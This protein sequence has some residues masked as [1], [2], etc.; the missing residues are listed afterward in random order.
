MKSKKVL[1]VGIDG[2]DW[3]YINYGIKKGKLPTIKKI[4]D[5]GIYGNLKSTIPPLTFPAWLC[6]CSGKNP[7]KIGY[8][9]YTRK[10]K[11]SYK[12]EVDIADSFSTITPFWKKLNEN[13]I[14]TG[15]VN[16]PSTFKPAKTDE[17]MVCLGD[18]DGMPKD[19][20]RCYPKELDDK[21]IKKLGKL[22]YET[23]YAY[24][25]MPLNERLNECLRYLKNRSKLNKYLIETHKN[26]NLYLTVFFPDAL[27][28]FIIDADELTK[29]YFELDKE[30]NRLIKLFKPE[31]ILL[32]SDHGG[33]KVKKEFYIN[34]FLIKNN[35]LKLKE[36]KEKFL[37]RIGINLENIQ[38]IFAKFN[39]DS[40]IIKILPRTFI[41]K[42]RTVVP[43]KKISIEDVKID[44]KKTTAYAFTDCGIFINVQGREPEGI[45]N[46]KDYD[47]VINQI[48]GKL[49]ELSDP[50]T[51]EKIKMEVYRKEEIYNGEYL[52]EAPDIVYSF[53]N[54]DYTQKLRLVGEIF[55]DPRDLGNHK[56]MGVI[57]ASGKHIKK[58]KIEN[59]QLI[60]IAPTI[61]KLFNIQ[62]PKDMDGK[63]LDIFKDK[64]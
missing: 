12:T 48:I 28:H 46:K 31:D 47:K 32:I 50:D 35:L 27:Q 10:L 61:L 2:G 25:N 19:G 14:K 4:M 13:K 39:L 64:I 23:N 44:W 33:G 16:I 15:I 36:K 53:D 56:Q 17:F 24:F 59:A 30:I 60:D 11:K 45:V 43:I 49:K 21:I 52:D 3:R 54:W 38:K 40:K 51:K 20:H 5:N 63:V 58:G 7:G 57:I 62:K 22:D 26:L 55:K 42:V 6:F 1:I 8:Y 34:E 29:Y 18:V 41:Y 9:G 37:S